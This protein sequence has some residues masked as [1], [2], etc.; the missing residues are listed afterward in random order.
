MNNGLKK[1]AVIGLSACLAMTSLAG[2]SKKETFDAEAAA[3]TIN[4]T[5]VSAGVVKFMTHYMQ[6]ATESFYNMYFGENSM[7]QAIDE[8]GTTLGSMMKDQ[9]IASLTQMILAEQHMEEYGV[10][11][12]DEEKAEI[13]AAA[14]AFIEANDEEVLEKMGAT[15]ADV[16]R[17]LELVTIQN[18]MEP[19]MSADVDTEVSDEEAAQRK[20]QYTL[21]A[22]ETEAETEESTEDGTEEVTEAAAED[23]TEA[24]AAEAE[25]AAETEAETAVLEENET[26]KT[27][28]ADE[29]ETETAAAETEEVTEAAETET[30]EAAEAAAEAETAAETEVETETETED[31]AMAAAMEEAYA[32]AAEAIKLMQAGEDFEAAVQAV[33]PELSA[34]EMTFDAEDTVVADALITATEGLEDGTLVE[35]PVEGTTG[36]YVVKLVTQLDR[37]ATDAEKEEIVEQRKSDRISEL[38]T[39]WEEAAEITQ[40]DEVIAQI[41][42]DF[43]LTVETET[44]TATEATTEA[45]TEAG[46]EAGTEEVTEAPGTEAETEEVTEAAGTE[47]GTEADT[48][49]AATEAETEA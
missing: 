35:T 34:N 33:D 41:V 29:T 49:A 48:E 11:L 39:E 31:P 24:A 46:T 37:E 18:K 43:S 26:A 15:Q 42:F 19:A 9:N 3:L 13:T 16:E 21:F 30:E 38:Y 8:S 5:E 20:I 27:Q 25:T 36:Y 23:V 1:A 22:A 12:S 2:C 45:T 10:S 17:Y 6:A 28:S 32:K 44:E 4:D 47:A 7:N 40:N 14:T